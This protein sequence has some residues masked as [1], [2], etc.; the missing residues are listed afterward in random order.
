MNSV[1]S[2]NENDEKTTVCDLTHLKAI[3]DDQCKELSEALV[4]H[5]YITEIFLK[6]LEISNKG[7]VHLAKVIAENPRIEK[8]D[9]GYN[10]ITGDGM[11][12]IG[13]ALAGNSSIT[14]MK[15]HRQEKDMGCEAEKKVV[16]LWDTNTTLQRLYI[17]LHDRT[18]N[19]FNTKQEVRNKDIARLKSQ[20]KDYKHLDP[21]T[22]DEYAKEQ[23]EK[24]KKEKEEKEAANAPISEKVES[25]GGPYTYKQLTCKEKFRPD[26]VDKG[27]RESYLSDDE[28]AEIFKMT[29]EEFGALAKWKQTGEKKKVKLH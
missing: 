10:K 9:L 21:A 28:F 27:K 12:A 14:E 1:K 13:E 2:I 4:K 26:D 5:E 25:T 23:A 3:S 11:I 6:E 19:N 24:K 18:C 15:L 22:K 16:K 20:G 7:A 29:K 17:T 8:M